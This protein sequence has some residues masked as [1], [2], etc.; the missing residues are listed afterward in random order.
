MMCNKCQIKDDVFG[1]AG[2]GGHESCAPGCS[3]PPSANESSIVPPVL[4]RL[5][6]SSKIFYSA[7]LTHVQHDAT[8]N[9]R[10]DNTTNSEESMRYLGTRTK[11]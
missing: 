3:T 4:S 8:N 5:R 7:K 9:I 1:K 2:G 11:R 10:L 6:H